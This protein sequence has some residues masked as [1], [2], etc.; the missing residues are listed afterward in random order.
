MAAQRPVGG[1]SRCWTDC[2]PRSIDSHLELRA[3]FGTAE[4][5]ATR[6]ANRHKRIVSRDSPPSPPLTRRP[7][8][9]F[10]AMASTGTARRLYR[11]RRIL[12]RR[13]RLRIH[14][15]PAPPP[16][17]PPPAPRSGPAGRPAVIVGGGDWAPSVMKAVGACALG[18]RVLRRQPGPAQRGHAVGPRRLVR[19]SSSVN[20]K[21]R[22][23][24]SLGGGRPDPPLVR[25]PGCTAASAPRG[26]AP[27]C[28][29]SQVVTRQLPPP[30]AASAR[31]AASDGVAVASPRTTTSSEVGP[32]PFRY[33]CVVKRSSCTGR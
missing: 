21:T 4:P 8:S 18:R 30:M 23:S 7:A 27:P 17:V 20:C 6:T 10:P 5:V 13:G 19:C 22:R 1:R 11:S 25:R 26:R 31:A 3:A 2:R 24:G 14:A 12:T 29:A 16:P 33:S 15:M 28:R 32:L 9:R